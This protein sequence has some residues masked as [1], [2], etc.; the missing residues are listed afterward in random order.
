MHM[1]VPKRKKQLNLFFR[2][3][4]AKLAGVVFMFSGQSL[5]CRPDFCG[6]GVH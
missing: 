2:L 1:R 6:L 3:D 5:K 4:S